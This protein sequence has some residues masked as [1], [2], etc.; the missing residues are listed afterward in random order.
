MNKTL[1]SILSSQT[2]IVL[3]EYIHTSLDILEKTGYS[4]RKRWKNPKE[5]IWFVIERIDKMKKLFFSFLS[6]YITLE[7]D[8]KAKVKGYI[9]TR[10]RLYHHPSVSSLFL[11]KDSSRLRWDGLSRLFL[12]LAIQKP[13]FSCSISSLATC[14]QRD[15]ITLS[16]SVLQGSINKCREKKKVNVWL[17]LF[18]ILLP[19][20][21]LCLCVPNEHWSLR[22]EKP[23]IHCY[24]HTTAYT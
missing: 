23:S 3:R 7:Q 6:A 20:L 8:A 11:Q 2:F 4:V 15:S 18:I 17:K 10:P 5:A 16:M 21:L 1:F 12:W 19:V 9:H 14:S 24:Y 13:F 22:K